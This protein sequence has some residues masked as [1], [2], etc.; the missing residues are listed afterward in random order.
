MSVVPALL[1]AF[2]AGLLSFLLPCTL[3]LI[4]GYLS[5]WIPQGGPQVYIDAHALTTLDPVV[6]ELH[7][8]EGLAPDVEGL[9]KG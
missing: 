3:P 9:A 1:L 7:P 2:G 5:Q 4:P 6:E 8:G